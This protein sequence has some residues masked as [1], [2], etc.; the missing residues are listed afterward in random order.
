MATPSTLRQRFGALGSRLRPLGAARA[1]VTA[2]SR[3]GSWRPLAAPTDELLLVP[4]D[5][6]TP[7][8]SFAGE[9]ALG[10]LGLAGMVVD[11]GG[12]SPFA[13]APPSEAW[14]AELYGFGW[15]RH[16][17][18]TDA[19]ADR[20]RA[21]RLVG[22][23][24]TS[25]PEHVAATIAWRPDVAGRRTL[26]WLAN[27]NLLLEGAEPRFYR[28]VMQGLART[29]RVLE[30]ARRRGGGT[31]HQI[32]AMA[33]LTMACL[34][35]TDQEPRLAAAEKALLAELDRQILAD[36]GHVS[37]NPALVLDLLL[38][39]LPLRHCYQSR[40]LAPPAAL[41]AA[42]QRMVAFLRHVR[43][44]DG[45][46]A[47]F[48]GTG[49]VASDALSTVLSIDQGR[50]KAGPN[51]GPSNFV[52]LAG[53]DSVIVMDCGSAPVTGDTTYAGCLAFE[54]SHGPE[55]LVCNGGHPHHARADVAAAARA[56]GSHATLALA[57]TSSV[58]VAGG[59]PRSLVVRT[60][61]TQPTAD[62]AMGVAAEHDG[63]V[64]AFNLVHA[65]RLTLAADGGRID[66]EDSLAP[67]AGVHRS[68]RDVPFAIHLPLAPGTAATAAMSG[69]EAIITLPSGARW[70]LDVTGARASVEPA[71]H[72]A[73][74]LGIVACRQLVLR[75]AT[76]GATIVRW[77][78]SRCPDEPATP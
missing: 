54:M 13:V 69:S 18:A 73:H 64:A 28:G 63:Y 49:H 12:R 57:A 30:R 65:R 47:R 25:A 52:R 22:D 42:T 61:A 43:L 32:T 36:G 3:L 39:L 62:G 76:P 51:S 72:F 56:T 4:Q 14:A 50:A 74:V 29:I 27:A 24:L 19:D 26:A 45:S 68:L 11:L 23:W 35:L 6:R 37:R 20:D 16:L 71:R 78:L 46:L 77:S 38:D 53:G 75:G 48:N 7:D 58:D 15:L 17:A 2:S 66:V 59:K 33:G 60:A 41:L 31:S 9:L 34:A 40:S 10:Q 21:R 67:P 1:M 70:R 55:R 8:P 44:G 5:P